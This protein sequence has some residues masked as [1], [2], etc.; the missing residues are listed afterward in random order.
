MRTVTRYV[1][2]DVLKLFAVTLGLLTMLMVVPVLFKEARDQGLEPLQI[3]RIIP[4][5]LP[6]AL[7]YTVPATVLFAVSTVYGRMSGSNEIVALK[8]LGISPM[9]VVWPVLG[10]ALVLSLGT[11]AL[12]ELALTWGRAN[13]RRVIVASV[14]EIAYSMLRT[15][16]SFTAPNFSIIV[17]RVEGRRLISPTI[18]FKNPGENRTITL[19][20]EEATLK[21]DAAKNL[22]T[23]WCRRGT[24]D[25]EGQARLRFEDSLERSVPLALQE[26]SP[27]PLPSQVAMTN[28]PALLARKGQD[29]E[30]LETRR[31]IQAS[32]ALVLGNFPLYCEGEHQRLDDAIRQTRGYVYRLQTERH[33]RWSNGFSCLCF[34][35]IGAPM[36]I[37]R[38][39]ADLLT[40][41]FLCFLPI[42]LIYYPLLMFGVDQAK[43]GSLPAF[44]VWAGNVV[45]LAIGAWLMQRVIRY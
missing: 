16:R 2:F 9:A 20:A 29:L 21:S 22:M 4:Y 1:V 42:L 34:V 41:F 32:E 43:S 27:E 38:R 17:R 35:M 44:T 45:V 26:E 5:T 6:E 28:L 19:T 30:A 8:S 15:H 14:E 25:V 39:N 11:M 3:L 18:T 12:N 10:L 7:R 40:S 23:I 31:A 13:V 33:R 24:I 36:A 37:W